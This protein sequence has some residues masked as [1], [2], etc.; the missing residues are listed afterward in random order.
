M[1]FDPFMY[2]SLLLPAATMRTMTLTVFSNIGDGMPQLSP[3]A[4]SVPKHGKFE[5][6][7]DSLSLIRNADKL[8]CLPVSER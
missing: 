1:T 2:L 6:L 8:V 4:I 5:D 7:A 3:Y